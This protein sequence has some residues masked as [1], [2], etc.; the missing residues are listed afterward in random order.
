MV[1]I[2]DFVD[3][4]KY[5][6][7]CSEHTI[8]AYECDLS[9][10]INFLLTDFPDYKINSVTT[11]IIR[12]WLVNLSE[13]GLKPS[14]IN[15]KLTS[16]KS[17]F[18][19]MKKREMLKI[20]PTAAIKPLK[21]PKDLP[22]YL[23]ET[24]MN[25]LLNGIEFQNDYSGKLDQ[26][27]VFLFYATGMRLSELTELKESDFDF[28][29]QNISVLGKRNK[30][31]IIPLNNEVS[32]ILNSFLYIKHISYTNSPIIN[33][34]FLTPSGK[35]IYSKFVYRRIHYYLGLVTTLSK[36]SPHV[37]RHTF[38]THMLNRGADLNAIKEILGHASLAATQ[39]YTHNSIEKLKLVY[40]QAH[41]KA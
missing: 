34:I 2:K 18:N 35:K 10:F 28:Y 19:F 33:Y 3:S 25:Q 41:P 6:K 14:S 11:S 32:E 4:L 31:R 9:D 30:Q 8:V 16:L 12:S 38:A 36:R 37:I 27:I 40:K 13:K 26:A 17:Y 22:I 39:I 1:E 29:N 24:A 20:N 23:S 5:E 21:N 7:R 15:R